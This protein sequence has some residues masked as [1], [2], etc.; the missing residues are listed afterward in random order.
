[1]PLRKRL[2][3]SV[4]N[5][6]MSLDEYQARAVLLARHTWTIK[7]TMLYTGLSHT[8]VT[9]AIDTGRI[10]ARKADEEEG[11]RGGVW[12]IEAKSVREAYPER[13]LEGEKKHA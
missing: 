6:T 8:S 13:T 3:R 1:M 12:L 4:S 9:R 11:K 7:E 2:P 5:G 10:I